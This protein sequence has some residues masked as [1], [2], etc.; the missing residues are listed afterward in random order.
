MISGAVKSIRLEFVGEE[1][2]IKDSTTGSN[3]ANTLTKL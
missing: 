1:I 3:Y 2:H